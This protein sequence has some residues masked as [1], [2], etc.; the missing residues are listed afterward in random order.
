MNKLY[1][2]GKEIM[3]KR[4]P[5]YSTLLLLIAIF[6][7]VTSTVFAQ[8]KSIVGVVTDETNQTVPG[9]SISVKCT[10]TST[11]TDGNGRFKIQVLSTDQ[12]VFNYVG[13]AS[14]TITV[15]NRTTLNV[16]L[17][18]AVTGLSDVVVVG[19]GTTKRADLT[20]A[21]G[22]VNMKDL[23]QAPV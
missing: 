20:G 8:S 7:T 1:N 19:Y 6:L 15:G 13:Y 5:H 21:I 11:Q 12:L 18:S 23:E 2:Q 3:R 17:K 22:S 14:Q 10:K 4:L 16:S 9:V